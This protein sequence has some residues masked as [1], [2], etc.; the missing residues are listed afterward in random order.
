MVGGDDNNNNNN[1]KPITWNVGGAM[2]SLELSEIV[3]EEELMDDYDDNAYQEEEEE[4][5]GNGR[6]RGG[7]AKRGNEERDIN[8]GLETYHAVGS[9]TTTFDDQHLEES[10]VPSALSFVLPLAPIDENMLR[11]SSSNTSLLSFEEPMREDDDDL[12]LLI[13]A[14]VT[15]M[16]DQLDIL[17]E[18]EKEE[19]EEGHEDVICRQEIRPST[20]NFDCDSES[21]PVF[22]DQ[23]AAMLPLAH[24]DESR[25]R[26]NSASSSSVEE[27]R[28]GDVTEMLD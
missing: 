23:P 5:E 1:N 28:I 19:E 7:V 4:E 18:S 24:I 2:V 22:D 26:N 6:R 27:L 12:R 17:P 9:T 8:I 15:E 11:R 21:G 16:F 14:D 3:E 20:N 13:G 10:P 25:S